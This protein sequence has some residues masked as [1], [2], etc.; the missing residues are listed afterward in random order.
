MNDPIVD[1]VRRAR[2]AYAASFNFD[3]DAMVKDLQEKEKLRETKLNSHQ[4]GDAGSK[5]A[6]E[7]DGM[8]N[9]PILPASARNVA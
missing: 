8:S 9:S 3:L 2:E 5:S 7:L 6:S 4:A 1:E